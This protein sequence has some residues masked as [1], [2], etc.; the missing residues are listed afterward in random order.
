MRARGAKV[1]DIVV[2]VVAADDGIHAADGRSDPPMRRPRSVPMIVAINKS[3]QAGRRFR[4][5]CA[6]DLLQPRAWPSKS[7]GGDTLAHRRFRQGARL[8]STSSRK[9]ILLQAEILELKRQPRAHAAQGAIDRSQART[10][11]RHRSRRVLVQKGTLKVGDIFDGGR[12]NGGA[13]AP[14]VDDR[15]RSDRFAAGPATPV[16]VHRPATARRRRATTFQVVDN[17]ARAR[18]VD[19]V[20]RPAPFAR[21]DR[22]RRRASAARSSRC[23]PR[24][25]QGEAKELAVV[26]K[27]DVQGSLEAIVGAL[28]QARAPT[29]SRCASCTVRW[30]ASPRGDISAGA[31]QASGGMIIGFNVRANPQ[32]REMAKRDGISRSAT[33]RSSTTWWTT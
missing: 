7:Y 21:C 2:L 32:A 5:A 4:T 9:S 25:R 10:R 6:R 11:S 19:R 15:G 14:C 12:A 16:E 24:S 29:K 20:P 27:T 1:T 22:P 26:V 17:D 33:T 30:A 8:V 31:R 13:C 3:R 23:S 18:E 28:N